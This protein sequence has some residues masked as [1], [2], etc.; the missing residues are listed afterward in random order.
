LDDFQQVEKYGCGCIE[1]KR[2]EIQQKIS[3]AAA[4]FDTVCGLD[5][6]LSDS[7]VLL[8]IDCGGN[9]ARRRRRHM[10]DNWSVQSVERHK[11]LLFGSIGRL[12]NMPMCGHRTETRVG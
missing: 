8:S 9:R 10:Q 11:R 7:I 6:D 1:S 4:K 2:Q 5:A 3:D 12:E